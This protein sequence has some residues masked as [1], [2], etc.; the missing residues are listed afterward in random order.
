MNDAHSGR[1]G[2][3][4]D[5]Q[6]A[7]AREGYAHRYQE[8]YPPQ[9]P[10]PQPPQG[11]YGYDPYGQ[12]PDAPSGYDQ[13]GNAYDPYGQPHPGQQPDPSYQPHP[14]YQPAPG[15]QPHPGYQ[16]ET[17][18]QPEQPGPGYDPYAPQQPP[19]PAGWDPY[20]QARPEPP[21]QTGQPLPHQRPP[22]SEQPSG[23]EPAPAPESGQPSGGGPG[24]DGPEYHTEEFAFVEDPDE[25]AEDVIDW[26]KFA[27]TRSERRDE[28]KRKRRNRITALVVA[29]VTALAGGVGYLWYTDALPSLPGAQTVAD[30]PQK[31]DVIVVHLRTTKG[32]S[33]ST[34][35]LVDNETTGKATLV[36]LPNSLAL[37]TETGE[38]TT[39]GKSVVTDGNAPT[40]QAL[41]TLLGADIKGSWRLDTPFLENLVN[42]VGGISLDTDASVPSPKKGE[43]PLVGKGK[44][45]S[46]DGQAAVGY[47]TLL[48]PGE[49]QSDQLRRFGEVMRAVLRQM[50]SD[51]AAATTVVR[52][53]GQVP[54][55][56]LSESQLGST[57]AQLADRAKEGQYE[58]TTLPVQADGTLSEEAT[59]GVVQ[60]V[61]G[62]T[63]KSPEEGATP[64]VSV[65]N[66]T[67]REDASTDAQVALLNGGYSYVDGGPAEA[68]R[69]VSQ[70]LY[71]DAARAEEAAEVA[72]TLGLPKSV[73]RKGKSDHN[74]DMTVVLGGDYRAR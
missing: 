15:Y 52:T 28:R 36:L 24:G 6:D 38:T 21:R 63:V 26:L 35:L 9:Q 7:Y 33:S 60:A 55:P 42:L 13:Y 18:Y 45:Q 61:L 69:L 2:R 10:Q 11:E 30:G 16:P 43:G 46:L 40:R 71:S 51:P 64:R 66:A 1:Y 25:D 74:A 68:A 49:L 29:L 67:G 19:Q 34:A 72:K 53:L 41:S 4:E 20:R 32:G 58:T 48:R 14:G 65:H 57:L 22:E 17:G 31:R 56:S 62:G 54:D 23:P 39:L 70:V 8:P 47:A 59:D 50:S 44:D 27:E 3:P 73:V 12:Q 5:G 37:S